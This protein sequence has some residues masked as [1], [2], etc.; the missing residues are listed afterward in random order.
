VPGLLFFPQLG[1]AALAAAGT[2]SSGNAAAANL[3]VVTVPGYTVS[4]FARGSGANSQPDAVVAADQHLYVAYQNNTAKDGSDHKSTV[5]L[6]Y[7]P[8]G[9]VDGTYSVVGH[10]DGLRVDPRT[11]LLWALVNN[12]A[13]PA[14][15]TINPRT[16]A[17]IPYQF[18]GAPHGG[19]YDDV[20]FVGGQAFISASNPTLVPNGVNKFPAVDLVALQEGTALLT[21]VLAGNAP[22]VDATTQKTTTL[23]EIDPDAMSVDVQGNVVL[24]N[25]AGS[26]LVFL[27][28]A[29]TA[30]QSVR[31]V[32]VGTQLDD[33]VWPGSGSG[34]LFVVDG[35][36]N[37]IYV[38]HAQFTAGTAYT[39]TPNDSGVA[40]I[41][42]IVDLGSGVVNPVATGFSSATG[43]AFVGDDQFGPVTPA[44][45]PVPG[46]PATGTPAGA[47]WATL[48]GLAL[49]IL[50]AGVRL[51]RVALTNCR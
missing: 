42:G 50:L 36:Q 5:I 19:G 20:A 12:D 41:V 40:G 43:L 45:G 22:A 34:R 32:L 39:S 17:T 10:C 25:Q 26:E 27:S 31:R 23:N 18:S 4:V 30:Q 14:L 1:G 47:G 3:P 28:Q 11:H 15:Y 8:D 6:A 46:M 9:T 16:G 37:T 2:G 33:T 7:R 35:K 49:V 13:N 29:G 24:V 38:L 48:L 51:R 21:P 44:A